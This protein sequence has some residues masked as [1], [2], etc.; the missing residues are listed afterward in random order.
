[1]INQKPTVSGNYKTSCFIIPW[2]YQISEVYYCIMFMHDF[3]PSGEIKKRKEFDSIWIIKWIRTRSS[4]KF[5]YDFFEGIF[6]PSRQNIIFIRN[7]IELLID[8]EQS[9]ICLHFLRQNSRW[10]MERH[11]IFFCIF[12]VNLLF[13]VKIGDI[14]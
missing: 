4:N 8:N 10:K 5:L 2:L 7:K 1:M 11:I 9:V 6:F 14:I 13:Y 12:Q 3:E